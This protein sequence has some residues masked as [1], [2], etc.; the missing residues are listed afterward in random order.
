MKSALL[1][2]RI[3]TLPILTPT[4]F[5]QYETHPLWIWYDLFGDQS[6]KEEI[7][8]FALKLMDEGVFHEKLYIEGLEY[9]EIWPKKPK[10]LSVR[11]TI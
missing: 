3:D 11:R 6:K 5:F 9:T 2:P 4:H 1:K 8:E 7:S 10:K